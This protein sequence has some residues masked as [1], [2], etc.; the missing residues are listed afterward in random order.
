[1]PLVVPYQQNGRSFRAQLGC[2]SS[3]WPAAAHWHGA[4]QPGTDCNR[5]T[6]ATRS[7]AT[8]HSRYPP[9]RAVE[10]LP[11]GL[12]S[13]HTTGCRSTAHGQR[14]RVPPTT[15]TPAA[16]PGLGTS[17]RRCSGAAVSSAERRTPWPSTPGQRHVADPAGA[18]PIPP[19]QRGCTLCALPN[20]AHPQRSSTRPAP[21][22]P[23]RP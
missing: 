9:P 3:P 12:G 20:A 4:W 2:P 10:E 15:P 5:A 11:L 16:R 1:M 7:T 23:G 17:T 22:P 8:P 21:C 18:L 14:S 13:Q 6:T 19:L